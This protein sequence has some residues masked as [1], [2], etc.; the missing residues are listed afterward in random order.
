MWTAA[1]D[2]LGPSRIGLKC[3]AL[4]LA[5]AA[6]PMFVLLAARFRSD[7]LHPAATGAA[8]GAAVGAMAWVLVDLWCP[9]GH[10]PHLLIGHVLPIALLIA[11]GAVLGS[12]YLAVRWSRR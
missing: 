10:L 7:P 1:F 12:R 3:L 4:S 8:V 5:M 2:A 11:A 9:V 6:A